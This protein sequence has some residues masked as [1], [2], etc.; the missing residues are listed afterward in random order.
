MLLRPLHDPHRVR[1]DDIRTLLYLNPYSVAR[2]STSGGISFFAALRNSSTSL[3]EI[4]TTVA[5][6]SA[7]RS[8]LFAIHSARSSAK[9][10]ALFCEMRMG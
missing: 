3:R 1:A 9:A 4:L 2:R 7:I 5:R 6:R 10:I 8:L